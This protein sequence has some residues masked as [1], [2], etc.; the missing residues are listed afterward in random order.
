VAAKYTRQRELGGFYGCST[1]VSLTWTDGDS[2]IAG[3]NVYR[4]T[5]SGPAYMKLNSSLA[6]TASYKDSTVQ[7][8]KTYFYVVTAVNTS[9][10]ESAFSTAAQAVIP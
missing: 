7:S 6:S 9:G 3:Y 8:G 2:G 5:Q 1:P 4:S 10:V